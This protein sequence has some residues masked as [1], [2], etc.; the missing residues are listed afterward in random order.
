MVPHFKRLEHVA[1]IPPSPAAAVENYK[2]LLRHLPSSQIGGAVGEGLHQVVGYR[3]G[4]DVEG[5][6]VVAQ[7]GKV[8]FWPFPSSQGEI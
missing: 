2:I 8:E 4:L 7:P 5:G 1:P 3:E 6:L